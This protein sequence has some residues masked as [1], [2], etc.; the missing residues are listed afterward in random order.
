MVT[1][2]KICVCKII[3]VGLSVKFRGHH[4][5]EAWPEIGQNWIRGG[6]IYVHTLSETFFRMVHFGCYVWFVWPLSIH[7]RGTGSSRLV[8]QWMIP[9]S[10]TF[11]KACH[12]SLHNLVN[13]QVRFFLFDFEHDLAEIWSRILTGFWPYNSNWLHRML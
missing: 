5:I 13:L 10:S 6:I 3:R 12:L 2:N 4:V 9:F 7:L 11:Y 8:P 1:C